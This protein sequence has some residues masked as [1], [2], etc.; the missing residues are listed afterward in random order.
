MKPFVSG[1]IIS[2]QVSKC[3]AIIV[4]VVDEQGRLKNFATD[5]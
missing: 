5:E 1:P 4:C 2:W 3:L